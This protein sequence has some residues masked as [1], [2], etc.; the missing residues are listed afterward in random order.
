MKEGVEELAKV[1]WI[2]GANWKRTVGEESRC[3]DMEDD[4]DLDIGRTA[5]WMGWERV[6]N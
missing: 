2:C 4:L 6:E 5:I 3:P 1:G